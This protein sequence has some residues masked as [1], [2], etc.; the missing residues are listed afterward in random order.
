MKFYVPENK[1]HT[2]EGLA[3]MCSDNIRT[4][5]KIKCAVINPVVKKSVFSIAHGRFDIGSISSRY[6]NFKIK[7]SSRVWLRV[8]GLMSVIVM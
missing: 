6:I 4:L 2:L 7:N 1:R 3:M 8:W 5:F